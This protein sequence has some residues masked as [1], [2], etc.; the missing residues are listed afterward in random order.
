MSKK[1]SVKKFLI[2]I[3]LA[4]TITVRYIFAL[5]IYNNNEHIRITSTINSD[6]IKSAFDK[7]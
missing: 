6:P 1:I 5:P 3:V 2:W 7:K 4:L